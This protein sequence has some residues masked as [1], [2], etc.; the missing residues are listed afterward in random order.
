MNSDNRFRLLSNYVLVS[1]NIC[2]YIL[3]YSS[4]LISVNM[5]T[6]NGQYFYNLFYSRVYVQC[7]I[8]V[9]MRCDITLRK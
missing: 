4:V 9:C 8:N 5:F 6:Y 1:V 2:F 3:F 7:F